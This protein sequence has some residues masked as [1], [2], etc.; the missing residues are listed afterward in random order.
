MATQTHISSTT[1]VRGSITG[2]ADLALDGHVEGDIRLDGDLNLDAEARVDGNI[3]ARTVTINGTVKGN[4]DASVHLTVSKTAR[5]KGAITAPILR[6]EEGA[7][8]SGE[9]TIG[10]ASHS[11]RNATS[12]STKHAQTSS[13][14]ASE[15]DDA[16]LPEGVVARKV[17]VKG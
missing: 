5:I 11:N 14:A 6:L 1:R 10:K 12:K 7:L 16:Q 9:V 4:I 2:G 8:I 13:R 17:K 15:D 3:D